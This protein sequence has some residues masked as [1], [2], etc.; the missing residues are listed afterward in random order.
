MWPKKERS[1]A[2]S[3]LGTFIEF[4]DFILFDVDPY[5]YSGTALRLVHLDLERPFSSS[6]GVSDGSI[7]DAGLSSLRLTERALIRPNRKSTTNPHALL[8]GGPAKCRQLSAE[9]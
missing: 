2:S 1:Q 6:L 3:A 7:A 5:I 8:Q 9:S 4:P